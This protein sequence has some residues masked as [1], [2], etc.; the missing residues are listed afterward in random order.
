MK[1]RRI[2]FVALFALLVCSLIP[3]PAKA[4]AP[5]DQ[6][7]A[8]VDK[9]LAIVSDPRLKSEDK[10]QEQRDQLREVI[11]ARFDFNEMAKRSLGP[12]WARHTLEEQR[13]FVK[14]FTDL[15]EKTYADK[16]ESYNGK[17]VLYTR[18]KQ[19]GD[20]AKVDTK[21]AT[22]KS[23]EYSISYKL[24][25]SGGDWKVYDVVIENISLVNNYRSQFSHVLANSSFDDLLRR[26][27]EK[28]S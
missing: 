23:E 22:K 18:E 2:V 6:I 12:N 15:L 25:S 19:D 7:R 10:K 5:T 20:D 17:K 13:A 8:T 11:S 1:S 4:G 24:H 14:L 3:S 16:I 9:V 21:L 28:H 27:S 26:M